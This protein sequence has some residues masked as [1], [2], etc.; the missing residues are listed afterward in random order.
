MVPLGHQPQACAIPWKCPYSCHHILIP[1]VTRNPPSEVYTPWKCLGKKLPEFIN[2]EVEGPWGWFLGAH[3]EAVPKFTPASAH[4]SAFH[5]FSKSHSS[6]SDWLNITQNHMRRRTVGHISPY[7]FLQTQKKM[8]RE[9][10]MIPSW[11]QPTQPNA[12]LCI[13]N[14]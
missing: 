13:A 12:S 4:I 5:S 11:S 7:F 8:D 1:N 10:A 2:P 9:A 6:G 3:P 14:L